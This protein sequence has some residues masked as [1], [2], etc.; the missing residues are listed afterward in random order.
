MTDN[1]EPDNPALV[2]VERARQELAD[3]EDEVLGTDAMPTHDE[4]F[5]RARE[6]VTAL[7]GAGRRAGGPVRPGEM[8]NLK[9]S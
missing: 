8:L 6:A 5:Q 1:D 3:A 4:L 9:G 2:A 7:R